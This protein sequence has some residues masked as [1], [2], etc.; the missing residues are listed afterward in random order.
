MRNLLIKVPLSY[1]LAI[2]FMAFSLWVRAGVAGAQ[3]LEN[4]LTVDRAVQMALEQ[5]LGLKVQEQDLGKAQGQLLK[6]KVFTN[7]ELELQG[8]TDALF[9]NEG[10]GIYSIGLDQTFFTG[11]KRRYRIGIAKVGLSRTENAIA[12]KRRLLIAE[13]KETFYATLL[14]QERLQL[15]EELIEINERLVRLTEGRFREGFSPE[16]DVNLAKIHLQQA[17]RSRMELEKELSLA[18]ANLNLLLGLPA[19]ASWMAQGS[20][21][22]DEIRLDLSQLK[23]VALTQRADLK[24]QELGL[25]IAGKE[26]DLARAERLP[27]VTLS[28]DY[29]QERTVLPELNF[30]ESSRLVGLKLSVPIPLYDRN[31]G[32]IAQARVQQERESLEL[33]LLRSVIVKEVMMALTRLQVAQQALRLYDRDILPL[34]ESHLT[35]TQA[36]YEQGL[37]GILNV[38]EGQRRFSEA[39]LGY[40]EAL[41]EYSLALTESERV[42]G[43]DL[44]PR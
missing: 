23:E 39:R 26:M 17:Q 10:E 4:P 29:T 31:Q 8:E 3:P 21:I 33:L 44:A 36:A 24:A 6:A 11:P 25:D 42:V 7:P 15:S 13:V 35:L 27:D 30:E 28:V 41:Y 22:K 37:T 16:L 2:C 34:T 38:M 43:T 1:Y 32:E 5:N 14:F 40:L 9:S 18:R 12:N 20:F 19:D